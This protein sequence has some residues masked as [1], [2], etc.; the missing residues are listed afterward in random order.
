MA[1]MHSSRAQLVGEDSFKEFLGKS[2]HAQEPEELL[3]H[4]KM[5]LRIRLLAF[6][7]GVS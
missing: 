7:Y 3:R 5:P 2:Y 1:V 6:V 4:F